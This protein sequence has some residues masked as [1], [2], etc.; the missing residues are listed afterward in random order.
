MDCTLPNGREFSIAVCGFSGRIR[1]LTLNKDDLF[2]HHMTS[3][4]IW[5]RS[6]SDFCEA[7]ECCLDISCKLN[8]TTPEKLA[9]IF[10]MAGDEMLDAETAELWRSSSATES[11]LKLIAQINSALP[12]DTITPTPE[13]VTIERNIQ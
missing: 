1:Y 9:S 5:H 7:G 2:H 6:D 10:G 12:P 3:V 11:F 4:L 8:K 13:G